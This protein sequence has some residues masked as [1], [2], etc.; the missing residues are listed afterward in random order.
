MALIVESY[1]DGWTSPLFN[2]L[3]SFLQWPRPPSSLVLGFGSMVTD[4]PFLFVVMIQDAYSL[5]YRFVV[6]RTRPGSARTRQLQ[7]HNQ[8]RDAVLPKSASPI[9]LASKIPFRIQQSCQQPML[10]GPPLRND[11]DNVQIMP[12]H[13]LAPA[14]CDISPNLPSVPPR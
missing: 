13:M 6:V 11:N 5:L 9:W 12:F 4:D 10:V 2:I 14:R 1:H 8:T 7:W 3:C